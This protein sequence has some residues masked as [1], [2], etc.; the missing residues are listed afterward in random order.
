MDMLK[1]QGVDIIKVAKDIIDFA[2]R[3]TASVGK[4]YKPFLVGQNIQFDISFLQ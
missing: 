3:N 2:K 4:Q 1:Q